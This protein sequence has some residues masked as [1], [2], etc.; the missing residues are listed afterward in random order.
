VNRMLGP[1]LASLALVAC[2]GPEASPQI[3]AD[4]AGRG[5]A[6]LTDC[7]MVALSP[8]DNVPHSAVRCLVEAVHARHP[9]PFRSTRPSVEGGPIP[10]T[11][12]AADDLAP[13][14][15]PPALSGPSDLRDYADSLVA[16]LHPATHGGVH[17]NPSTRLVTVVTVTA[18]ADRAVTDRSFA[19][20]RTGVKVTTLRANRSLATLEALRDDVLWKGI[21]AALA[22]RILAT[23]IDTLTNRVVVEVDEITD[24]IRRE[25]RARFGDA[26]AVRSGE[27]AVMSHR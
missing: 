3:M 20:R 13:L 9:A 5:S 19:Q 6:A 26:V 7:G 8:G 11:Y 12:I 24:E 15:G 25:L 16:G 2:G 23:Q 17:V 27:R 14:A 18:G 10:V 4:R 21:P 22:P 1:V